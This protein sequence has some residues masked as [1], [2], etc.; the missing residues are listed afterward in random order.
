MRT[1]LKSKIHRATVTGTELGYEGSIAIDADLLSR[2]DIIPD[3]QVHVLNVDTGARFVTYAISAPAGS[4]AVVFN[5]AAARLGSPG[6]RV[7]VL[8]YALV[9]HGDEQQG[10]PTLITV[11]EQ[12][13]PR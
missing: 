2:A 12:N 11:D 8:S 10:S 13:R 7:I 6:D 3:E 4:G 5:G 9:D 1:M